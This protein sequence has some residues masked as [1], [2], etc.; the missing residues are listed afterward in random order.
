MNNLLH[1]DGTPTASTS[2]LVRVSWRRSAWKEPTNWSRRHYSRR[3]AAL[4]FAAK[5]A[6]TGATVQ[7][8]TSNVEWHDLPADPVE[9]D[10]RWS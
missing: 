4:A 1:T 2:S 10:R 3:S 6:A 8:H 5:L 9:I 7:I